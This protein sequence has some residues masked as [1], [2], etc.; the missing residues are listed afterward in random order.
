[1]NDLLSSLI[2]A[3]EV[4]SEHQRVEMR[5]EEERAARER[6][7]WEQDVAYRES[8]E[9]DRA[10]EEARRLQEKEATE[11]RQRLESEQAAEAA[12]REANRERVR[13]SLPPEPAAEQAE[14]V[15]KIRFRLPEGENLERRF[16]ANTQLKVGVD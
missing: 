8:L 9:V 4:F 5:E 11:K 16:L 10:K 7:K 15:A 14:G 6:V 1:M 13:A 2:E 12:K 3:V